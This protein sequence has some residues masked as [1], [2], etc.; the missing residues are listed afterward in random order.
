MSL[1]CVELNFSTFVN[2]ISLGTLIS[3]HPQNKKIRPNKATHMIA[4]KGEKSK[5]NE[6][7]FRITA[8]PIKKANYIFKLCKVLLT[9]F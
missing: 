4:F 6:K 7:S 5:T 8:M 9:V 1:S 3:H 2:A